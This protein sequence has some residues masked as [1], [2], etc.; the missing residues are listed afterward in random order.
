MKKKEGTSMKIM[1]KIAML[2][3]AV[4]LVIPCFSIVTYAQ[5]GRISFSDHV[6]PVIATGAEVKVR[7]A[8][9]KTQGNFV[10]IEIIMTYD[11][12]LL[13][14]KGGEGLTE[15]SPGTIKYVGDARND[16]SEKLFYMTFRALKAGTTVVNIKSSEIKDNA[17]AVKNYAH[18][19]STIKIEGETVSDHPGNLSAATVEVNG[20]TYRFAAKVPKNEIPTGFVE[21]TL[22]YGPE[23]YNVIYNEDLDLYLAYL[24]DE[25]SAGELFMYVEEDATFAPYASIQISKDTTIVILTN[26][27]DVYLPE[28]YK[29][30]E[31]ALTVNGYAFPGWKHATK[32]GYCIIYA[33]NSHGHNELYQFDSEEGTY[34]RFDAPEIEREEKGFFAN[35]TAVLENHLDRV[36]IVGGFTFL[37]LILVLMILSVKLYNRNAELDELYD[38]Y[39]FDDEDE[40]DDKYADKDDDDSDETED[41]VVFEVKEEQDEEETDDIPMLVTD[42]E[43]FLPKEMKELWLKI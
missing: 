5:D 2:V 26:V 6:S 31:D 30:F 24:V 29:F 16:G 40:D 1:K 14:F 11:T 15:I 18:G 12:D 3:L 34:Q 9:R 39:G 32:P 22:E 38:K 4:C 10:D 33:R 13:E 7:G 23:V 17:G 35:I 19:S 21:A 36:V 27:M 41:D 43:E 8:I 25:E 42:I 37:F 20:V 28:D